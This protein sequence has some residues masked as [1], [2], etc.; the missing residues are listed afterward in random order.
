MSKPGSVLISTRER[1]VSNDIVRLQDLFGQD[2][3]E[4]L[5]GVAAYHPNPND[6]SAED[7]NCVL[8]G[9]AAVPGSSGLSIDI[10]EGY[11]QIMDQG[12]APSADESACRIA[13]ARTTETVTLDSADPVN[14]R[15]DLVEV[16]FD[17]DVTETS[18]R[19]IYDP[20]TQTFSPQTVNKIQRA[21]ITTPTVTK[22]SAGANPVI[23]AF[24][25]LAQ[26][27][28]PICAVRVPALAASITANDILDLRPLWVPA[29]YNKMHCILDGFILESGLL[30]GDSSTIYIHPGRAL[31]DGQLVVMKTTL[32]SSLSYVDPSNTPGANE[33]FYAYLFACKDGVGCKPRMTNI[34]LPGVEGI[35]VFTTVAP[36][37][38]GYPSSAVSFPNA[39]GPAVSMFG[40]SSSSKGLYLGA[41][42]TGSSAT[43]VAICT[44]DGDWIYFNDFEETVTYGG[45]PPDTQTVDISASS[46][47]PATAKMA[48]VHPRCSFT[49]AAITNTQRLQLGAASTGTPFHTIDFQVPDAS[50]IEAHLL[51]SYDVPLDSSRRFY[52]TFNVIGGDRWD[53]T[54]GKQ[55]FAISAVLDPRP[56][57][58]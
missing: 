51:G 56:R 46:K 21:G 1:A 20:V 41:L 19:D 32:G 33:W 38:D 37:I 3:M 6:V 53:T 50:A 58:A 44:R 18:S 28:I 9:L 30:N 4:M 25:A 14:P 22:G 40:G 13:R 5:R 39:A 26:N 16:S 27:R 2:L 31:V 8:R 48:R 34:G 52:A 29:P 7:R 45:T 23:P 35:V 36:G 49:A 42:R 43:Q 10:G 17:E 54:A 11:A 57:K 24:S 47:T 55:L 15:Y 12:G